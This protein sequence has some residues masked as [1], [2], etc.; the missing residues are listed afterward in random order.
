MHVGDKLYCQY[1]PIYSMVKNNTFNGITLPGIAVMKE[2]GDCE[3]I[4]TFGY[5]D[6]KGRLA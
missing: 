2:D 1:L 4:R 5:G 6:F 3:L